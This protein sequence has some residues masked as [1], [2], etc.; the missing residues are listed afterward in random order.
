MLVIKNIY[1]FFTLF[2]FSCQS[3]AQSLGD[4]HQGGIIFY[5][6]STGHGLI[7][8]TTYIYATFDWIAEEPL[9]SDW[10]LHWSNNPGAI[11]EFIGAGQFNTNNL[12]ESSINSHYAANLVS[13]SINGG[14]TDWFLPSRAELWQVMLN[15]SL[16]DSLIHIYGG[17]TIHS[18]FH[19]S[20]TQVNT[21]SA[22]VLSPYSFNANTGTPAGPM[23]YVWSKSNSA[24]V[25]AVRCIDNN[26]S[27]MDSPIFGCIDTIAE[28]FDSNAGANDFSCE[29][30]LGCSDQFACNYDIMVTL[31]QPE[32]CDYSCV[33]CTDVDAQNYLGLH[34]T[35]DDG[36]CLYCEGYYQA[37]SVSYDSIIENNVFFQINDGDL[38]FGHV[39]E[40][41]FNDGVCLTDGC[42]NLY[43]FAD[44]NITEDWVGNTIQIGDFS[45][46]LSQQDASVD[47]YIGEGSCKDVNMLGC[48]DSTAI[49]FS[50]DAITDDDS[51]NYH[52][53]GCTDS[54]AC[55]WDSFATQ[56]NATCIFPAQEY[57]DCLG[58]CLSDIDQ[59]GQCD[60][61]DFDDD[62]GFN[63]LDMKVNSP[64]IMIDILGV[65]HT[66][67][68]L[69]KLLFY[70]YAD[71]KVV[72]KI[73]KISY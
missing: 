71:G 50:P 69:N 57:L 63:E 72:K 20:S 37:I 61:V 48:T 73:R 8:D 23:E 10:G 67:H 3:V 27:F 59:D 42:Y 66:E 7:I 62:V 51:C 49:N 38:F 29:Y 5:T 1:F 14:Y 34:I 45:Y 70:I 64:V 24:L 44:C 33:G 25:R 55:N 56:D 6:D 15:R 32:L 47:F 28:N 12:S 26:C 30:I 58:N 54:T 68:K 22:W 9:L 41:N 39:F 21:S 11:E 18:G 60:Q 65:V 13:S 19:W 31:N 46:T 35:I 52:L 4:F 2:L 16:I 17:D 53:F 43:M 36:S 40:N